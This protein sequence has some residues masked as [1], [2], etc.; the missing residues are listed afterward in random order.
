MMDLSNIHLESI[1]WDNIKYKFRNSLHLVILDKVLIAKFSNQ[2]KPH[3]YKVYFVLFILFFILNREFFN[4]EDHTNIEFKIL[5]PIPQEKNDVLNLL[6]NR[7]FSIIL[8]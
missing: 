6:K 1:N 8:Q 7:I 5:D 4:I 3:T 2:F